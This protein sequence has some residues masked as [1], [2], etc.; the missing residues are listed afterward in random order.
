[1]TKWEKVNLNQVKI[2]V[3]NDLFKKNIAKKRP[4]G[5]LL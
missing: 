2:M 3:E 5:D 4:Q 1:M